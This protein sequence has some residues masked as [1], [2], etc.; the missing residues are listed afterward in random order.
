MALWLSLYNVPISCFLP[1]SSVNL[2]NHII[3][4]LASVVAIDYVSI[5]ESATTLWTF[6][7][8]LTAIPPTV[9]TYHVVLLVLSL[10][11]AISASTYPCRE[12]FEP[13]K[14]NA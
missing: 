14:H 13:P 8:Q 12:M 3:S 4:L 6:E 10:L 9:N 2:C 1:N 11:P 5:I 7:T